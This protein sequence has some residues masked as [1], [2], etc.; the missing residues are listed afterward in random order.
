MEMIQST[1]IWELKV[2]MISGERIETPLELFKRSIIALEV[3]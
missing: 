3:E 1:S 2:N